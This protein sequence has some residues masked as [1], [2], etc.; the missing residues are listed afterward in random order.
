MKRRTAVVLSALIV[1]LFCGGAAAL[2]TSS[3][4]KTE[5]PEVGMNG[6]TSPCGEL[7]TA[8]KAVIID[9]GTERAF[10]GKYDDF[11][12]RGVYCCRNC[13]RPLYVSDDKFN[14]GCGWPAFDDEQPGA[15]KR[16]PDPDGRRTEISC[17]D[18]GAH[19][20][21]VFDG[22]ELTA[23]NSRHCVNSVSLVFEPQTSGRLRRAVF[24]GG[25]FWGV[26]AMMSHQPGVVAAVSGYT[27]GNKDNP[28]Y[29]DVCTGKT[30]HAEAVEVLFDPE[31]TDFETLCRYFLEIHDPAQKNRQGPD[32]GTQY[33]SAIFYLDDEQ[34]ATADKLLAILRK[35]GVSVQ[36][37]VVPFS[38]FW[39]AEPYHQDYYDRNGASPYC[40]IYTRRF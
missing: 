32:V 11:F 35:K 7:S 38:K 20:G 6:Q 37:E 26:E 9:H 30:G 33:R 13:G 1:I 15:V 14:S 10:S 2:L 34:K 36:T 12:E 5:N 23:K 19:L 16:T 3:D 27:G 29:R 18:C 25:C 31:K 39:S 22:E 17:A 40:H 4:S 21:H 8:E 28:S 24:A